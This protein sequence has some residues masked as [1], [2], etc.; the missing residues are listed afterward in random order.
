MKRYTSAAGLAIRL[1]RLR[2]LACFA[3]IGLAQWICFLTMNNSSDWP[4]EFRMDDLAAWIGRFGNMDLLLALHYT[5]RGG[6]KSRIDYTLQRLSLNEMTVTAVWALVFAGWFGLYWVFQIGML[7]GMYANHA[8]AYGG[9]ENLLFVAAMRSDYFHYLLPL[10]EPWGFVRNIVLCLAF[11]SFA[12]LGAQN[13]RN[14]RWNPLCLA[15]LMMILWA[16]LTPQEAGWQWQDITV[17]VCA[18]I[19]V[20][21]D[22]IWSWRWMRSEKS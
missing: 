1:T 16:L 15:W 2:M 11:G 3:V 9:S 17:T 4:L 20:I 21:W 8:G 22:W 14:G 12:A 10:Y 13:A 5:L 18:L 19:C 6:K 7:F